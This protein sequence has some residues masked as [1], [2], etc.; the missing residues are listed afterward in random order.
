MQYKGRRE[1]YGTSHFTPVLWVCLSHPCL[2]HASYGKSTRT[3]RSLE[4]RQIL[5]HFV[6]F[7][8]LSCRGEISR[9]LATCCLQNRSKCYRELCPIARTH[10]SSGQRFPGLPPVA[11]RSLV[12]QGSSVKVTI[13]HLSIF[14]S[15]FFSSS[16]TCAQQLT[17][18]KEKAH[19]H[20][21]LVIMSATP[22]GRPE[23]ATLS[24][25]HVDSDPDDEPRLDE[26]NNPQVSKAIQGLINSIREDCA[27]HQLNLVDH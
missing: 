17:T 26:L 7:H 10:F 2:C 6:L 12:V 21:R 25:P 9:C 20:T 1:S 16:T 4:Q 14:F 3:L 18:R 27:H 24:S 5:S 22:Q 13:L 8:I 11:S 19:H 23:N 15:T